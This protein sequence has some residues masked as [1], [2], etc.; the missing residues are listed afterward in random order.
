MMADSDAAVSPPAPDQQGRRRRRG[1][2]KWK[3]ILIS[4][5]CVA[6]NLRCRFAASRACICPVDGGWYLG[7]CRRG[8]P[9]AA[10][11]PGGRAAT[12]SGAR[13]TV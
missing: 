1:N 13:L 3:R 10:A 11:S 9:P 8:M 4:A 5:E 12:H 6:A 7:T 2:T